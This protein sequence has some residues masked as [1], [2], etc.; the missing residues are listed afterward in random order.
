MPYT[1]KASATIYPMANYV[2][3]LLPSQ[4]K[5]KKDA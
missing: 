2:Y 4:K 5:R 3:R 1:S